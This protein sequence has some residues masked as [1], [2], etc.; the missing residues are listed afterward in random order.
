M[1]FTPSQLSDIELNFN[2]K[3]KSKAP[4][5]VGIFAILAAGY[6]ATQD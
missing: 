4:L 6:V 2:Q 1:S 3:K 5:L